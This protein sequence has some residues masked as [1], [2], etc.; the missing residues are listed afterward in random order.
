MPKNSKTKWLFIACGLQ[1]I[2]IGA[3][4]VSAYLPIAFGT[5]V[6]VIAKG[7]DPRDLLVGNYV[8]LDYGVRIPKKPHSKDSQRET[9]ACIK[10]AEPNLFV[11]EVVLSKPP[12]NRL[13]VKTESPKRYDTTLF[14]KGIDIYFAPEKEAQRIQKLLSKPDNLAIVTLKIFQGK[15]RIVDLEVESAKKLSLDN[16]D[17][18]LSNDKTQ[19]I[20]LPP[21]QGH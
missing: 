7:Y 10:E 6:K 1:F 19:T 12:K 11:F 14:L 17:E 16:L 18:I 20:E 2:L 5:E 8:R 15:A 9:F 4:F 3:M 13:C 21:Q